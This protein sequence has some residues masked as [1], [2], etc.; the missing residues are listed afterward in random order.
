MGSDSSHRLASDSVLVQECEKCQNYQNLHLVSY[1]YKYTSSLY[2]ILG[3]ACVVL[4]D[5]GT[6]GLRL[7]LGI[8]IVLVSFSG[9]RSITEC[10]PYGRLSL[11]HI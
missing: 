8:L 11:I 7:I 3:F 4:Q 10:Y 5:C 9:M 1:H 2:Y 6:P